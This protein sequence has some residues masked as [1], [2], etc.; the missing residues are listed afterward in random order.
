MPLFAL[1]VAAQFLPPPGSGPAVFNVSD[2]RRPQ[3][4][5]Q[6]DRQPFPKFSDSCRAGLEGGDTQHLLSLDRILHTVV[7]TGRQLA[8]LLQVCNSCL[9]YDSFNYVTPPTAV[10]TTTTAAAT[11]STTTAV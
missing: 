11:S 1:P 3:L 4:S 5:V 10:C 9:H 2:F 6:N 8:L 7:V